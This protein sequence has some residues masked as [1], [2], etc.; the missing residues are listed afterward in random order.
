MTYAVHRYSHWQGSRNPGSRVAVF[1]ER[2]DAEEFANRISTCSFCTPGRTGNYSTGACYS[3]YK[4][5]RPA[6]DEDAEAAEM[7]LRD[8]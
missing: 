5:N 7:R 4:S 3:V 1:A 2:T 8:A 6:T